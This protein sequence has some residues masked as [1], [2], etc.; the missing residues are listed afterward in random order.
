MKRIGVTGQSG[1]VGTHLVNKLNQIKDKYQVVPFQDSFFQNHNDLRRFVKRCDVIVHLAAMMRS[2]IE[3]EVYATNMAL[4]KSLISAM[5][6]EGVSVDLFFASS[7]QE[8]NGSEYARCKLDGKRK[9]SDWATRHKCGFGCM[10]FPNL[11]GPYA[12]PNSHSFVA[13]FCYKLLHS[14]SP[15]VI[16]DNLI[17]LKYID[18]VIDELIPF[19]ESI[20][21]SKQV[22]QI[23]LK[24][25][26]ELKVTEVLRILNT[27]SEYDK[28]G[29][30]P[31][32]LNQVDKDLYSTFISYKY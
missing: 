26:Y 23:Y 19:F 21:N 18:S 1:F 28:K 5:D 17:Q 13:T 10:I 12:K 20:I 7:I 9:L 25:D 14:E 32:L 8:N 11:F 31:L 6:A 27:F 15:V 30:T 24:P 3:G 22:K 2:P 16:Q 29:L 4:V